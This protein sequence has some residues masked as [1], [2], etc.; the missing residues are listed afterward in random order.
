LYVAS[1]RPFFRPD[2]QAGLAIPALGVPRHEPVDGGCRYRCDPAWH[3]W[4]E[5]ALIL[6]LFA[7]ADW[8]E[9]KSMART[10]RAIESLMELAPDRVRL[11][12]ARE[13]DTGAYRRCAHRQPKIRLQP[14]ER[15]G[16][17]PRSFPGIAR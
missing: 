17:T 4:A 16:L 13:T 14:G 10:T 3:E 11:I 12:I 9:D 1:H 8:I 7:L 2:A 5:G 6:W 15:V